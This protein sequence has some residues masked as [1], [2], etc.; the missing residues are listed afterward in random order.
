MANVLI[1]DD[2]LGMCGMLSEMVSQIGHDVRWVPTLREGL[3]EAGARAYDVVL[4]DVQLPD[5]NGLVAIPGIRETPSS[6]EV[7]IITGAGD[8][9][10]AELAVRNGAWDYLE[11]P[12]SPKKI[13]LPLSRVLQYRDELSRVQ[14]PAVA[15]K[16]D[17]IVGTGPRMQACF[18]VL[19][20]AANSGANVLI[21]G[22]T[23]TGKELFARAI[24][25]NSPR[26]GGNFVVV[27]CAALPETLVESSLFGYER[28]AFT[29]ADRAREGL[30]LQAD[31]GTLFLDEIGELPLPVQRA[32]LRVLQER[33]FRPVGG[34]REIPSDFRL[35]AAT[36]RNLEDMARAGRFRQDLLYR[37]R[38]TTLE[39][40]PLKERHGD[41]RDLVLHYT[42]RI[43]ERYGMETKGF[44]PEFLESL[45]AYNWPGNVR[46]LVNTLEGVISEAREEPTLF[47]KHLPDTIRVQLARAA[48][49]ENRRVS[50]DSRGQ[51][52]APATGTP[53]T[54]REIRESAIEQAEKKYLQ[55]LVSFTRGSIKEA[56]RVSGLGRTRLYTLLK[57][58]GISRLGWPNA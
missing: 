47:P 21:T 52:S 7:I 32:F 49:S 11:K 35:I 17:G 38:A 40:P 34:K 10:G 37:L 33:R 50:E 26:A 56:C 23:G 41:I 46:E 18:D 58:H 48:V 29:G 20:Q 30:I 57:K 3:R 2:D 28:G 5:G 45:M 44:S 31:G 19:A 36:N 6:P 24:H 14:K 51:R 39:L 16:L 43:C 54:Y 22:E 53:P 13:L 12:L 55:E 42:S 1:I 27:D 4:L 8:P 15:L 9:D 25:L